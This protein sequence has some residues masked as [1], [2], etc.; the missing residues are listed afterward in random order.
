M[1]NNP[2][3]DLP[4]SREVFEALQKTKVQAKRL[5]SFYRFVCRVER[6]QAATTKSDSRE[7]GGR[8][9]A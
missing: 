4:K 8:D 1:S 9:N 2:L 6:D 7:D 3:K 5:T